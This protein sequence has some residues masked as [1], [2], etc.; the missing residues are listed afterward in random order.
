MIKR[1]PYGRPVDWWALGMLVYEMLNGSPPFYDDDLQVMHYSI[2]S[3]PIEFPS[4]FSRQSRSLCS[5]LL[6]KDPSKRLGSGRSDAKEVR[7]HPFFSSVNWKDCYERRL[8]P[9]FVPHL[10]SDTD[11]IYFDPEF[12]SEP[13]NEEEIVRD[14]ITLSKSLQKAFEGWHFA[15]PPRK[16]QINRHHRAFPNLSLTPGSTLSYIIPKEQKIE[17]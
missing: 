3:E 4:F 14:Q 11:T 8:Q 7:E 16:A 13:I 9:P 12:T 2:V 10:K 6:E 15:K 1:Q 5:A 17:Y